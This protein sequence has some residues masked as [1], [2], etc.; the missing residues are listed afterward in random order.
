MDEMLHTPFPKR[1]DFS[2]HYKVTRRAVWRAIEFFVLSTV[3]LC[4]SNIFLITEN[5]RGNPLELHYFIFPVIGGI[6]ALPLFFISFFIATYKK[7]ITFDGEK[8]YYKESNLFKKVSWEEPI[9]NFEGIYWLEKMTMPKLS[10]GRR[11]YTKSI[12]KNYLYL[13]H[14]KSKKRL[15]I[16]KTFSEQ[17]NGEAIQSISEI[18]SLPV[19]RKTN[20]GIEPFYN[21]TKNESNHEI[22]IL[23]HIDQSESLS[24]PPKSIQVKKTDHSLTVYF[25]AKGF[26]VVII[27]IL[28]VLPIIPIILYTFLLKDN[29]YFIEKLFV[30]IFSF[31]IAII[32]M[33]SCFAKLGYSDHVVID[34]SI[35]TLIRRYKWN[36]TKTLAKI[37][38]SEIVT[39]TKN[40]N[41]EET[42]GY[43][44]ILTKNKK[45]SIYVGTEESNTDWFIGLCD[46]FLTP[47]RK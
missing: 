6:V 32:A 3:I 7:I 30:A 18:F 28:L 44:K 17:K 13:W 14:E 43:V 12:P 5:Y 33:A 31:I 47:K 15:L 29:V 20:D 8:I 25:P 1:D 4:A 10:H 39:I 16:Y 22:N 11:S 21:A 38:W 36:I 19:L 27:P 45:T 34:E 35:I 23:K 40:T 42:D 46:E 9:H 26:D 24:N 41:S 37:E 2:G